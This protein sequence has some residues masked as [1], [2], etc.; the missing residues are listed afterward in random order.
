MTKIKRITAVLLALLCF[1]PTA[2][3]A[4]PKPVTI[5]VN[6]VGSGKGMIQNGRTLVPLRAVTEAMGADVEW[7]PETREIQ[8]WRTIPICTDAGDGHLQS[9]GRHTTRYCLKSALSSAVY[10]SCRNG[11]YGFH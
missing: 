7:I 1:V 8:I 9:W 6:N 3:A 2:F 4:N 10:Q 11:C 5:Y